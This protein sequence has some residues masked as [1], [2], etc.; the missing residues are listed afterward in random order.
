M[1]KRLSFAQLTVLSVAL[2]SSQQTT[3]SAPTSPKSPAT[4]SAKTGTQPQQPAAGWSFSSLLGLGSSSK[5]ASKEEQLEIE[6]LTLA[7][8]G[9]LFNQEEG[10]NAEIAKKAHNEQIFGILAKLVRTSGE[11][12]SVD[13]ARM[14]E[15]VLASRK[16]YLAAHAKRKS[17]LEQLLQALSSTGIASP[18]VIKK[19]QENCKSLETN[20]NA[21]VLEMLQSGH[22]YANELKDA[23]EQMDMAVHAAKGTMAEMRRSVSPKHNNTGLYAAHLLGIKKAN[24]STKQET[25]E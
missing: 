20:Y 8:S 5:P 23:R 14:K 3:T 7:Q 13:I 9:K 6:I 16:S 22:T 11:E 19:A 17:S 25:A 12:G 21:I 10:I 18:A 15:E 2:L 4:D 1:K 24:K